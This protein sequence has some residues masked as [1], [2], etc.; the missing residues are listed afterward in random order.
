LKTLIKKKDIKEKL[1]PSRKKP[2]KKSKK[3]R[4]EILTF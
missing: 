3:E 1:T 4:R 2:S